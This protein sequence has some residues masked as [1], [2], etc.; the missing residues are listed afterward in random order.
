MVKNDYEKVNS[1][2]EGKNNVNP[3]LNANIFSRITIWWMN[4]IF[5]TGNKRPL[6][7][8]DL[9]PLLEEDKSEVLTENLQEEWNKE[10]KK[11]H[12]GKRPRF[13]K[14]LM[15]VCPWYEYF[16][17][18]AL[19]LTDMA[20]RM[21]LPVLLGFL[22]SYLMGIRQLDVSFKYI[23]P[24]FICITSLG[25]NLAQHHYQNRSALLGMR[26]RAAAT[27][28]LYKKVLRMS[29]SKLAKITSGHVI[30]LVSNDIQRLDLAT[31]NLFASLRSPFDLVVLG[32]LL[33]TLIG[34]QAVT[35]LAFALILIPYEAEMTGWVAKLRMQ[36]ARVTDKRLAVMNEIV[37]GIRAV[38]MYAWEWPYRDAVRAIRRSELS[39]LRKIYNILSTFASLQHTYD[40]VI[41]LIAFITLIFTG[42]RL[43]P[44]NVFTMVGLLSENR[45]SLVYGLTDGMQLIADCFASL[46]RIESFLLI[47]ELNGNG[48]GK[49]ENHPEET[50]GDENGDEEKATDKESSSG[51]PFLKASNITCHWNG[52]NEASVLNDVSLEVTEERLLL[53][54]GPVGCGKSS[55]LL[56]FLDELPPSTGK[57]THN[58]RIVYVPQTAWVYSGTLRDNILFNQPFDQ[59]KYDKTIEACDL[60]KDI[61]M[62]PE[63]DK[64]LLGERGASLSGGQRARVNLARAVYSDGDIYLMDDP[65]SAVDAK[66]GKHIFENCINGLLSN[67]VRVLVTH[68]LQYMKSADYIVILDK[69]SVVK[70]GKY[71]QMKE[72]GL[73][74]ESLEKEFE[75]GHEKYH[76]VEGG[77]VTVT[78]DQENSKRAERRESDCSSGLAGKGMTASQEDRI[79]GTISA[80]L[81]WN[82]FRA[83]LHGILLLA[84]LLLFLIAQASIISPNLWLVHLTRMKWVEQKHKLNLI[85]YGSLVGGA[86]FLAVLRGLLYYYTTLRCSENLHDRMVLSM[87]QS[88]VYF[89]DT[90]PSGR[91]L[92]RFSKDI[93]IVDEFLPPTSLLAVQYILQT[94]ASVC[95][96]CATNYW[97]VIGVIPMIIGF[98]GINRYYLKTSREIKRMEA[99]SQ[100]PVLA[101]LADTL[102]GIIIIRTYHMEDKFMQDFNEVQDRRSQ[103]WFL[104]PH[105]ARWMGIRLDFVC[106]LF[107]A[108]STFTGVFSTTD[109]G[110]LGLSLVYAISTVGQ[111]QFAMRQTADVENMMT[112]VERVITY[113]ELPKE[114]T[115]DINNKPPSDW[116]QEG[117]LRFEDLSLTYYEGGPQVLKKISINI[118]AREKVGVAGRTGAGKSSLVSALFRMP[119]PAGNI[120]IDDLALSSFN[121]QSTRPVISVITQNPT[122]FSGPLRI[123]LDPFSRFS[124]A[125]VWSV[126]EQVQ[127]KSKIMELPGELYFELSESGN[128]FGVG[129]RQLLCL[130]RSLLNKNKIIVMDEATANVDFSTD[131][132]IQ[133]TIRSKFQ[134]CTVITIAHRLNTIIDY[135][136]VLVMDKGTVVEYD[137]PSV[138]LQNKDGVLTE[139]F[140]NQQV[141]LS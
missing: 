135:D 102:E 138:L 136:K 78:S 70:Q 100:S 52:Q 83:G 38:K 48:N 22:I 15:R 23:L 92:N 41:C 73:D 42:I 104:V 13:W 58:G 97:A 116:P 6:E 126:L 9:F 67:K 19:V 113:T 137:K 11:R 89:F 12:Q 65:L 27:G 40:S 71:E 131:R 57:I 123:N 16:S 28:L 90:N 35:G 14:A 111:L 17:I 61:A 108:I 121:V 36:A 37:S 8:D 33:W 129:E 99:I 39:F 76:E 34:W 43:T 63:G 32:I 98:F 51:K 88:P 10:L 82:Y 112:A 106:T 18:V 120:Y 25:R 125:E 130:A 134:D 56:A 24:T 46:E 47:E 53:V 117:A 133:E 119:E 118:N 7:E 132:R 128:N 66:V 69:G 122:L 87:L 1:D 21:T 3:V 93:G 55:L 29:Q 49:E 74:I 114:P 127:M 107:V 75:L 20:N 62:L 79:V 4:K 50:T 2:E 64:T 59:E 26:F 105:S 5:V 115:Y 91:I 139:L 81:Y 124:D 141:A 85:I 109:A 30:N 94:L 110:T 31:Q 86:L 140:R 95:V 72:A 103:I 45:R 44:F 60:K 80:K 54:T 101:H 68:Q 77:K 96:T 84:L